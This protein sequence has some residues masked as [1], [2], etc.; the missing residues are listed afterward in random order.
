VDNKYIDKVIGEIK[1]FFDENGYTPLEN[2]D[3]KN[4][5]NAVR[6]EYS[7]ERQMYLLKFAEVGEDGNLGEFSEI[8]AWLFDDSQNEKDAESVGIDFT[9]TLRQKTGIKAKRVANNAV[10]LPTASKGDEMNITGFTKKILDT[11]PQ[12]KETYKESVAKY[13]NF[14]YLNF[15][16]E[17]IVPAVK[18]TI[19]ENSKKSAKKISDLVTPAY[20][21]GDKD[22]V[23]AAVAIL[24]AACYEDEKATSIVNEIFADNLHF[25]TAI[26][27]FTKVLS[28]KKKIREV[29]VK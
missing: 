25:K 16:G 8:E 11:Y 23:N 14:L 6:V 5:K 22:T 15:F 12:F 21:S 3:Y 1:P 29:L 24:A 13:G 19:L 7:D 28:S 26:L 20:V 2:G 9:E 10:D 4:D 18:G 17:F 27:S